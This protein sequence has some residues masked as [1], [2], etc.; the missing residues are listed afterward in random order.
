MARNKLF[1]VARD[2][3]ERFLLLL[4]KAIF[5]CKMA[6]LEEEEGAKFRWMMTVLEK[7]EDG[8]LLAK[9]IF[10]WTVAVL[11]KEGW[12]LARATFGWSIAVLQEEEEEGV[13]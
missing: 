4:A 12:L 11:E 8:L 6:V 13:A 2:Q 1:A 10:R 3:R 5:Q 9:A 7:E